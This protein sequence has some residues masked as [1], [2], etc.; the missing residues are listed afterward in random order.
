MTLLNKNKYKLLF[1]GA[2]FIFFI[3][4]IININAPVT[5]DLYYNFRTSETAIVIQDFFRNGFSLLHSNIP[6]YGKPWTLVFE[7]PLY[8]AI[9]YFFMKII[10]SDNIDLCGRLISIVIY[11][12]GL[13]ELI[14]IVKKMIN[15][16]A[17]YI[18]GL[19][20][21]I[22][23]FNL[24]WSRAIL[25]DYLSVLL[26]LAYL[27][28]FYLLIK[29][30]ISLARYF[31]G[32]GVGIAGYL[33][34]AT[35]MFVVVFFIMFFTIDNEIVLL[36]GECE[37]NIKCG[38]KNY[39]A[40]NKIRLLKFFPLAMIPVIFGYLWTRYADKMKAMSR[41]TEW[42]TSKNLSAWNYGTLAQKLTAKNWLLIWDRYIPL[43][44]SVLL[45]SII[46][47]VYLLFTEKKHIKI[48]VI[49]WLSQFM[50]IFLLFNLYYQHFYYYIAISPFVYLSL[51][52]M[53]YEIIESITIKKKTTVALIVIGMML[54]QVNQYNNYE[55]V[56]G[57]LHVD[58]KN[59]S[60]GKLL[61]RITA[62]DELIV[63]TDEEWNPDTL[64]AANRR[65]FMGYSLDT[66]RKKELDDYIKADNYT[67]LVTHDLAKAEY[68]LDTY[69]NILVYPVVLGGEFKDADSTYVIKFEDDRSLE[70]ED[71]HEIDITTSDMVNIGNYMTD[72]PMMLSYNTDENK[73]ITCTLVDDSGIRYGINIPLLAGRN[74]IKVY[75]GHICNA[76]SQVQFMIEDGSITSI[77]Y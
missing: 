5:S 40:K 6:V 13:A 43:C 41:Y 63:I 17:A 8:Q 4:R 71:E 60:I 52:I 47:V 34:K 12:S 30:Q 15:D 37:A 31:V 68:I 20:Y 54:L 32:I 42:L 21:T 18:V 45:F 59:N 69:D 28:Y 64:Y 73:S 53:I 1:W 58:T 10:H 7:F 27:Y 49:S 70:N 22:S 75:F 25:I 77:S 62:D 44:G 56:D 23:F 29:D 50:T 55:Y 61:E 26:S 46:I 48:V 3:L 11:Y 24:Y 65:G 38:I 33:T 57:I 16:N 51:G 67:T 39:F 66:E 72:K 14:R 76:I 36:K 2:T 9:I 19:V 74:N 35:T